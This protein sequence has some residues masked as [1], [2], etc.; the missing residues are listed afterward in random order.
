MQESISLDRGRGVSVSILPPVL[1]LPELI[2]A[3]PGPQLINLKGTSLGRQAYHKR[4]R[5]AYKVM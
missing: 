2:Q 5:H 3:R 1:D 4:A